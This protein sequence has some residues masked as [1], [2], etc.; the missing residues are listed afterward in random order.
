MKSSRRVKVIS[1]LYAVGA[2]PTAQRHCFRAFLLALLFVGT[3]W[4]GEYDAEI[5]KH[6]Q[7]VTQDPTNLDA[8]YQL[9]N[10]LAWDGR[11]EEAVEVYRRILAKEP[12]Y[13]EAEVGIARVYAWKGEQEKAVARYREIIKK[14]PENYEAYQGLGSLALWVNDFEKSIEYFNKALKLN[15]KDVVSIKG[16]GRAYLG[17]GDRRR[18]EEYFT[19]AQILEIRQTSLF[20][21]LAVTG[22][23]ALLGLAAFL[24]IRRKRLLRRREILKLELKI[25]RYAVELYHQ[26]KG[27]FPLALENLLQETR[28]LPGAMENKPYLEGI[29]RGERGFLVD[30]FGNR[31]WYNPET[32][33][34]YATTKGCEQW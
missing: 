30:P 20:V 34:V 19:Q 21:I 24:Y 3:G 16:L 27:N 31:Y 28:R 29:R 26:S 25:L 13:V 6:R 8:A 9:G 33:G 4:A 11:H 23:S 12:L 7:I 5:E 2:C 17:R 22:A 15:P 1:S 10:Y 32:G 14:H 18:A